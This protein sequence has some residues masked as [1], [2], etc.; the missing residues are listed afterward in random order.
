[1]TQGRSIKS[2]TSTKGNEVSFRYLKHSD[3]S[4]ALTFINTLIA[5]DTYIGIYGKPL[6]YNEE[7]RFIDGQLKEIIKGEQLHIVV[8]VNGQFVGSGEVRK[9]WLRRKK[10]VGSLHVALLAPYRD[11]GIGTELIKILLKEARRMNIRVIEL[12]CFENNPQAIHVYGK[13]GF[14]SIGTIPGAIF[15]KNSYVGEVVMYLPL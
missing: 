6:T 7:K 13:L 2:F 1:M 9:E 11:E 5:E 10:H 14:K 8:E 3:I 12:S 4:A 15:F